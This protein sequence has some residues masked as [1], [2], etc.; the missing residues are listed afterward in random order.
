MAKIANVF[1]R[2][3]AYSISI[4]LYML[5]YIQQAASNNV[6]TFASAQIFYSAGFTGQLILQQIFIADTTDLRWRALLSSLPDVPYLVT[7]WC[8]PPIAQSLVGRDFTN[9]WRWGYG[10]WAIV[11]PVCFMPLAF[12]LALNLRRAHQRG[13]VPPRPWEGMSVVNALKHVWFE[14]DVFGLLLLAAAISLLL[15][16]LPLGNTAGWQN[17]SIIAML[18]IGC[19]C[20]VVFPLWESS[21]KLAPK[22]FLSMRMLKNRTVTVGCLM[23]FFYFGEQLSA[24]RP[25][26][27]RLLTVFQRSFTRRCFPTLVLTCKSSSTRM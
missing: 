27:L 2:L 17:P 6:E 16:P 15:V 4:V 1:G 8:G 26:A 5:G 11:L 12:S 21:H 9:G 18:V 22:P 7:V 13:I 14:L 23:G 3:E 19:V 24:D 10:L 25:S 20:L